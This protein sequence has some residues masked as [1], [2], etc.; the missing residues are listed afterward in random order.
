MF[1]VIIEGL[2][3]VSDNLGAWV[4]TIFLFFILSFI[5]PV[6]KAY[7]N[8]KESFKEMFTPSGALITLI[9]VAGYVIIMKY[10]GYI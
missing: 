9:L 10:L 3:W 5:S 4:P 1:K 7:M 2:K 6:K 8:L